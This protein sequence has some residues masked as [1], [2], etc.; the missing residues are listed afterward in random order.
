MTIEERHVGAGVVLDIG[1]RLVLH[2]GDSDLKTRVDG[3]LTQGRR[4]IVL[5]L[6]EVSYVDSAG[7]GTLVGVCLAARKLEGGVRL[8]QPSK[9]LIDLLTMAKLLSV[10]DICES[11]GE[12]FASL[13]LP[14]A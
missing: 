2:D 5:N 14:P 13:G 7:L 10:V 12:A 6:R 11:E 1:G 8:L 4:H 9:R 3:L